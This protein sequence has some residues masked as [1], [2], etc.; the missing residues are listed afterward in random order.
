M[1]IVERA[2]K[3][4]K[5][6][7]RVLQ[8]PEVNAIKGHLQTATETQDLATEQEHIDAVVGIIDERFPSARVGTQPENSRP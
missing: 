2:G 3:Q 8:D 1:S 4:A 5:R 6:I 7:R